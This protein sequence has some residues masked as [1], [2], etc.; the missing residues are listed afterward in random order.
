MVKY[1]LDTTV[2]IALIRGDKS[3]LNTIFE[4]GEENCLVSEITIAELFYGAS[5]SGRPSHFQDVQCIMDSFEIV[6]VF[7]S[8]RTYGDIKSQLEANGM[9]IDEFDLLIGATALYNSMTL[10]THNTKHFKRISNLRIED[11]E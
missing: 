3:V 9:R 8:L 7:P 6:P 10:V 4:K 11:W 2:C 5:K 1:I